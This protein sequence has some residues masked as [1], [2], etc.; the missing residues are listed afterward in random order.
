MY[1]HFSWL[2][3]FADDSREEADDAKLEVT[4]RSVED[5][6][7][8][9]PAQSLAQSQAQSP[10]ASVK[11][12]SSSRSGVKSEQEIVG[13]LSEH[14]QKIAEQVL[15]RP[16]TGQNL[17]ED[18]QVRRAFDHSLLFICSSLLTCT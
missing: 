10:V 3:Y 17:L 7:H 12:V 2:L 13:A 18:A 4:P 1:C 16:E 6:V 5:R 9:P 11:S 8:S 14:A 15:S